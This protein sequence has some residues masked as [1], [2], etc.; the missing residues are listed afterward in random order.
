MY[1][2][3]VSP[4]GETADSPYQRTTSTVPIEVGPTST[5]EA[6]TLKLPPAIAT[7]NIRIHVT[8]PAGKPLTAGY[9]TCAQAAKE[10]EG[11]P[12]SQGL[13]PKL[14]GSNCR[15]LADRTYHIR[16]ERTTN[17]NTP[18]FPNPPEVFVPPGR[19]DVDVHLQLP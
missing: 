13:S 12:M 5:I 7:R 11:Y 4:A 3:V 16:L 9:M 10:D 1:S 18:K 15:A 2:L 17:Y 6:I 19:E 14:N 8:D